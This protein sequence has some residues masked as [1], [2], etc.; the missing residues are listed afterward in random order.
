MNPEYKRIFVMIMSVTFA[1]GVLKSEIEDMGENVLQIEILTKRR[2]T[3]KKLSMIN[4]VIVLMT[5]NRYSDRKL[6]HKVH[7]GQ[8]SLAILCP[9]IFVVSA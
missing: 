5:K 1:A 4:Q 7:I 6:V 9:G 3:A 2:S 8:L